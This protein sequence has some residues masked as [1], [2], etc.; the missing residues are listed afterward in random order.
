VVLG[1][2]TYEK[3][4]ILHVERVLYKGKAT[5]GIRMKFPPTSSVQASS[6]PAPATGP[7]RS[8]NPAAGLDDDIPF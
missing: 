6:K 8:E 1:K 4:V 2:R 7:V 3:P 5:Q